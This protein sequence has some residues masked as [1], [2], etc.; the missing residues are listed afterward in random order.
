MRDV[1]A[2][3]REATHEALAMLWLR[4]LSQ[5]YRAAAAAAAADAGRRGAAGAGG[6]ESRPGADASMMS[7]HRGR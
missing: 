3:R 4:E 1:N 7:E 5:Y 2:R 6:R